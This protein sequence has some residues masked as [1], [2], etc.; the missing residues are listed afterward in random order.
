MDRAADPMPIPVLAGWFG[1]EEREKEKAKILQ[2][3]YEPKFEMFATP[4]TASRVP[5]PPPPPPPPP[6]P[7]AAKKPV[8]KHVDFLEPPTVASPLPESE[9]SEL[10]IEEITSEDGDQT[11]QEAAS[12]EGEGPSMEEV[13]RGKV[14]DSIALFQKKKTEERA[15]E[16]EERRHPEDAHGQSGR[17][18]MRQ[19]AREA[20]LQR[21]SSQ[22]RE[23]A[24]RYQRQKELEEIAKARSKSGWEEDA[25]LA[26]DANAREAKKRKLREIAAMRSQSSGWAT[27]EGESRLTSSNTLEQA[28]DMRSRELQEIASMRS[29]KNW[30]EEA[31]TAPAEVKSTAD[32]TDMGGA[33]RN[34][35]S[36][37]R[38]RERGEREQAAAA[39][40]AVASASPKQQPSPAPSR[41]IG[42]LL[43]RKTADEWEDP[44]E[45]IAEFLKSPPIA[46]I[47]DAVGDDP[48]PPPPPRESSRD[49][50]REFTATDKKF[51]K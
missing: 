41:R 51:H 39:A 5:S 47:P 32:T 36:S 11:R 27:E 10:H 26:K 15:A 28:R 23:E 42:N 40:A 43:S 21:T 44:D 33:F 48:M 17:G 49:Y 38:Q 50:M 34:V 6:P 1:E 16:E 2:K 35:A 8:K 7:Q 20:Y 29:H 12:P 18:R 9:V 13:T 45:L 14:K 22:D 37:W 46:A 31:T 25:G 4:D 19:S 24:E 30:E 3:E